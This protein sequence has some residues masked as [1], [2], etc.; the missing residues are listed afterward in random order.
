LPPIKEERNMFSKSCEYALKAVIYIA[1]Q[2]LEGRRVK[3]ADVA[4]SS[5]TPQAFIAKILRTLTKSGIVSSL[6]GPYGGFEIDLQKMKEL[7]IG[8]VVFAIDGD[9][10]YTSCSMGLKEC[11][12]A[13]PCP[14]HHK[15]V[16]VRTELKSMLETTTVYDLAQKLKSGKA[17]ILR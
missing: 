4:D 12:D 8:E 1:T 5:N 16:K 9:A 17:T 15:F 14:M 7:K 6:K 10:V 13:D 3:I 2:S 11:N